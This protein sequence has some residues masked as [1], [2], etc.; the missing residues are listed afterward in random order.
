MSDVRPAISAVIPTY[1]RRDVL[2]A[3]LEGFVGQSTTAAYEVIV[4]VDGGADGTAE[5]IAGRP[6]PFRLRVIEQTNSGASAARNAGAAVA[7]AP[8]LLFLDDDMEPE[9]STIDVHLAAHA[10][11]ADAVVGAMPLHPDSPTTLLSAG[12]GR[13]ADKMAARCSAPGHVMTADDVYTGH[14]SVRR[15]TFEALGG[16]STRFTAAGSFGNED[17]DLAQRLVETGAR[18]VFRPDAVTRQRFVVTARQYMRRA[19]DMGA[20]DV[21]LL[22]THP[23]FEDVDRI[24]ALGRAPEDVVGRAVLRLPRVVPAV[25][26]PLERLVSAAIERGAR[27][28]VAR[29]ALQALHDVRYWEGVRSAGGPMDGDAVRVLCWHAVQDL[30]DDPVLAPY[31]VPPA[32]LA[33]QLQALRDAGWAALTPDEVVRFVRTGDAVPRRSVFVTFDDCYTEM[34]SD[35]VR[36]LAAAD[37]SAAVFVVTA[38]VGDTNRWDAPLGTR[39]LPLAT[40]DEIAVL[41]ANGFELGAHSRTHPKLSSLGEEDLASEVDGARADLDAHG[42]APRLFAY[43]YGDHDPQVEA[44]T[45]AAGFDVAF[46]VTPGIARRGV[47]PHR[48]PRFEVMP[49]DRGSQLLRKVVLGGRWPLLWTSWR[50][51]PSV[52]IALGRPAR[53]G[54]R[55]RIHR[56]TNRR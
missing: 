31:G 35:G 28:R 50:G 12:V 10:D 45:A 52:V 8:V 20:A 54:V 56:M 6:W 41:H 33:E 47:H 44:A 7:L 39:A 16:F 3:S 2:L 37:V 25:T 13:W 24:A 49:D 32:V 55:R 1:E 5:A 21:A 17:V 9:A 29:R 46:T 36:V 34:A 11:G 48:V 53:R 19:A 18:I 27:G 14:L 23:G 4:V 42:L 22:R 15:A 30:S 51:R 40:W 38:R 26:R 43:P